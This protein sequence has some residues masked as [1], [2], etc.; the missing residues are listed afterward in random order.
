VKEVEFTK[1]SDDKNWMD[2]SVI[3][4]IPF[5]VTI[6]DPTPFV[7]A[8]F[9]AL[10]QLPFIAKG[11][12]T[13]PSLIHISR[14]IVHSAMT[15]IVKRRRA[16]INGDDVDFYLHMMNLR[17]LIAFDLDPEEREGIRDDLLDSNNRWSAKMVDVALRQMLE[18][19][20]QHMNPNK[21]VL[22][23]LRQTRDL[24][25]FMLE[26]YADWRVI[27]WTKNEQAK[28]DDRHADV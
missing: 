16:W 7:T 6:I 28:I 13:K 18:V 5:K 19:L 21:F 22:H 27:E 2:T 24:R 17:E 26:E 3:S 11:K 12:Y 1:S 14:V 20:Q 23:E 4:D 15:G 10:E 25:T 9:D 8:V